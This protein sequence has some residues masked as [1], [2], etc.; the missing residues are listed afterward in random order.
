MKALLLIHELIEVKR[1]I[2]A[3]GP[4][5]R[6]ARIGQ[7][8]LLLETIE[9]KPGP[10]KLGNVHPDLLEGCM[11]SMEIECQAQKRVLRIKL[12]GSFELIEYAPEHLMIESHHPGPALAFRS[13]V[14]DGSIS[15]TAL[16]R[17]WTKTGQLP[18]RA[19]PLASGVFAQTCRHSPPSLA[20]HWNMA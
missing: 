18:P 2:H 8:K 4:I 20:E 3:P 15:R 13:I 19:A 5:E 10:I 12:F 14:G 17:A 9:R 16:A 6:G 1:P 7:F 11:H